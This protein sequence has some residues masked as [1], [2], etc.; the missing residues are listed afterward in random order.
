[1]PDSAFILPFPLHDLVEG[2]SGQREDE[3]EDS[4]APAIG[5]APAI[6]PC[7]HVRSLQHW[8]DLCA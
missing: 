5:C 7:F 4:A 2:S 6:I 8:I 3:A 1:M